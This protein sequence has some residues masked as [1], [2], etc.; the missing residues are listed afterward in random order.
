MCGGGESEGTSL[1]V[2]TVQW[3]PGMEALISIG[4]ISAYSYS[5]F[6][7]LQGSIHLYFDTTCMLIFQ[8]QLGKILERRAKDRI[9]EDLGH[10]YALMPA[11][12]RLCTGA[13]SR[14]RYVAAGQLSAGDLFRVA[15]GETLA[16]DGLVVEGWFDI[17]Q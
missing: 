4:S 8:V 12:V 14:G 2:G 13:D 1:A 15:E 9:Q 10:Y 16:A 17:S 11:K 6:N 3:Q 7:L 5:V